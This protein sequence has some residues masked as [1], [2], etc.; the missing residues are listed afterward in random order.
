MD[1]LEDHEEIPHI[2]QKLCE[3]KGLTL[4]EA[5]NV[6]QCK[7]L[8]YRMDRIVKLGL[9]EIRIF[10]SAGCYREKGADTDS[11]NL[12]HRPVVDLSTS[13]LVPSLVQIR[14]GFSEQLAQWASAI[15]TLSEI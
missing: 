1:I 6:L 2:S 10:E 11:V 14:A 7:N 15:L 4:F 13:R 3:S 5:I 9:N 12:P 8:T